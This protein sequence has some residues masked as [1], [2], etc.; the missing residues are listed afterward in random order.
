MNARMR[1]MNTAPVGKE[2]ASDHFMG[3]QQETFRDNLVF[4]SNTLLRRKFSK[5][6]H[7]FDEALIGLF[8]NRLKVVPIIQ[9]MKAYGESIGAPLLSDEECNYIWGKTILDDIVGS[10][11]VNPALYLNS[12]QAYFHVDIEPEFLRKCRQDKFLFLSQL[13]SQPMV[14]GNLQQVNLHSTSYFSVKEFAYL[15]L[16]NQIYKQHMQAAA[17]KITNQLGANKLIR[18]N[19]FR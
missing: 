11:S 7:V 13:T 2:E 14:L 17:E 16:A 12:I 9:D 15:M 18:N 8:L 10:A 6:K 5:Q 19:V 1:E 4:I 3:N